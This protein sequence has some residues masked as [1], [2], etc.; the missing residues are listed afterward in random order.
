VSAEARA[1]LLAWRAD[2][3]RFVREAFGVEPDAWQADML[4]AFAS[5]KRLA[6]KACKGPGKTAVLAW[7]VWNFLATRPYANVAAT[8]ISGDNLRDGLWK[9]LAKWQR[10]SPFLVAAFE[11][12]KERIV[13]RE[14]P[15]DWWASARQWSKSADSAQQSNTLAGLHADYMLFVIDEAGGVPL[16]VAVTAEAALASGIETK[17]VMAGNPT[18][19]EGPLWEACTAQRHLWHVVEVTGDPDD[20][21]RSPRID[22]EW[23]RQQIAMF[24]RENPWVLVNVFG[25]FPPASLNALL[26]P[27]E[28]QAAMRR[29]LTEDAYSWSQKRIGI[30]CARFGDDRT[31]LFPRQGLAAF[32]PVVMRNAAGTAIAARVMAAKLRWSSELE[33]LDDTGGWGQ[34]TIDT[35]RAAGH[36]P[37]GVQFHGPAIDA[38]YANRR[39]E[40]WM[41]MAEWVKRGGALPEIPEIVAELTT[42]TFTFTAAGK[43]LLEDKDQ[44]KKRLGRSPDLA[45]ALALTFM[46]PEMPRNMGILGVP[47]PGFEHRGRVVS[48]YDPFQGLGE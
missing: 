35:L 20:P 10:Q 33:I 47:M 27:D 1:K 13:A 46:L 36:S 2:P 16:P 6:M 25:K 44:V 22:P 31:V 14:A 4:R 42:P 29:H 11:W 30:D 17:F 9:E 23:A 40:G 3:V 8:S 41:Q 24:G 38:R 26:G 19:T 18:H 45:D 37:I 5:A 32:P 21:N 15:A 34:S 12:Q 7:M 39:A 43:F 28:V 48:D